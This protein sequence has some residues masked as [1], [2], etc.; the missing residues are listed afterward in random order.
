M[1][2]FVSSFIIFIKCDSKHIIINHSIEL[3]R[4][5]E[6]DYLKCIFII[7]MIIFHLVYIGDTYPMAKRIVYTFHMSAFLLISGYLANTNKDAKAF[8]R[9]VFWIFFPYALMETGYVSLASFLPIR[10]SIED[11][12]ILVVCEKIF[13]S[14]IGPYWYLHT[15]ILCHVTYYLLYNLPIKLSG[16]SHLILFALS[17]YLLSCGSLLSFANAMYYIIGVII[18]QYGF[19]FKNVFFPSLFAVIPLVLLCFHQENLDRATLGGVMITYCAINLF[20]LLHNNLPSH[21]RNIC[22]FIGQN[23]FVILLFSP[24]F[25]F[26]S[27]YYLPLF[28]IDPTGFCFMCFS[29]I[30][31][32]GGC[33]LI[34]YI[35]DRLCL[36]NWFFGKKVIMKQL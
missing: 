25:T 3:M 27:K 19:N 15:L 31:T 24:I 2:S 10:E 36:S 17:L 6:L 28:A 11:L 30:F 5:K 26:I 22:Y 35:S 7:L 18:R 21:A 23:T 9:D 34:A 13:I 32:I 20:C 16:I 8:T 1:Q 12:S 14:P 4:I 33:L 29:V